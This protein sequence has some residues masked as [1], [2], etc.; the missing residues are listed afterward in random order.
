MD[1]LVATITELLTATGEA[2]HQAF[3]SSG[4]EDPEWARWYATKLE[5][6][7]SGKLT[8]PLSREDIACLLPL[9]EKERVLKEPQTGWAQY[10]ARAIV[11]RFSI[12]HRD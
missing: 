8:A 11:E 5:P 1:N 7:L 3:I 12:I 10:Y 4:G 9:L 2:H 6:E